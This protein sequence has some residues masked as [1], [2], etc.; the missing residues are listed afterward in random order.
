MVL[1]C[2]K[3]IHDEMYVISQFM[4]QFTNKG[5]ILNNHNYICKQS[6]D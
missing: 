6:S 1:F 3:N 4:G 2:D 5:V